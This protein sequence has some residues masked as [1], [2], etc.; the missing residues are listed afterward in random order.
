[1]TKAL[2]N[3]LKSIIDYA[4]VFPPARLPLENAVLEFAGFDRT[5]SLLVNRFVVPSGSLSRLS[6]FLNGMPKSE[7]QISLSVTGKGGLT[8][9][10]WETNLEV[11]AKAMT[12]FEN[13]CGL[14]Q[15]DSFEI[16]IPAL[17]SLETCINDL[18]GFDHI[19]RFIEIPW[20]DPDGEPRY[21]DAIESAADMRENEEFFLK[22]RTGGE[23]ATSYPS[24]EELG[25]WIHRCVQLDVPFKL[26][27]GLHEPITHINKDSSSQYQYGFLNV[28]FSVGLALKEDLLVDELL[29]VLR[30][31]S[32]NE[33]NCTGEKW[34]YRD[35][36]LDFD[37]ILA[38]RELFLGFGS[39]SVDEPVA[40]LKKMNCLPTTEA[41]V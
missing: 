37:D 16:K 8:L 4:G 39:C 1:M 31:T 11:D 12:E 38:S 34:V 3:G 10:E 25:E 40:G 21:L 17:S 35:M 20:C 18:S 22:A 29:L 14:A 41:V 30:E 36:T 19:D 23:M 26:T 33:F 5:K 24:P 6:S 2:E 28:L 9:D 13:S 32:S 15:I 27:A 7:M